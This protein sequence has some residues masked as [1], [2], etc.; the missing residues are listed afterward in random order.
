VD[1]IEHFD[2]I[3]GRL[4]YVFE[5]KDLLVLAFTHPSFYNENRHLCGGHNERLEFL[6]D[7]VLGLIL[8]SYL[9]AQLPE[10]AEGH[11]SHLRAHF[12]GAS[13]CALFMRKLDLEKFLMLGK[14]EA[15]NVG[16][17]RDRILADLFEAL[18][19]AIY[20]DGGLEAADRFFFTHFK[21]ELLEQIDKPLRNW[22][23]SCKTTLRNTFNS[24]PS[25]SLSKK[26]APRTSVNLSLLS[27]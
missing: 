25:I 15:T 23:Q 11:L 16:R 10:Q 22:K 21:E 2:E 26:G 1:Q 9:F 4:G 18:I 13:S 20:V 27:P 12:V 7:A 17:G 24:L 14:G 19:G 6:G 8:S 3:E 5:D